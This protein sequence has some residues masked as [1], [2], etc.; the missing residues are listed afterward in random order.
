MKLANEVR[1]SLVTGGCILALAI[2]SKY[3]ID[4]ELDFISQYGPVW[5]FIAYIGT[6]GKAEKSRICASPLFWS[7]AIIIVTVAILA[8]YVI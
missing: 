6:K 8:I 5:I 3:V 1:V 2:I 7:L 4:V